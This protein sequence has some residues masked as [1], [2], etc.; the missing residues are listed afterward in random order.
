MAKKYDIVLAT[1]PKSD[2]NAPLIA[3]FL[4]K[5]ILQKNGF[6]CK[7]VDWNRDLYEKTGDKDLFDRGLT[8]NKKEF[9]DKVWDNK[10]KDI[11]LTWIKELKS[12]NSEWVG[13]SF[14]SQ[15]NTH[16]GK[17]ILELI[18]KNIPKIKIVV[19]GFMISGDNNC[20]GPKFLEDGLIDYFI[21]GE[22]EDAIVNLLQGNYDFSGINKLGS[23]IPVDINHEF[24]PDYSDVVHYKYKFYDIY[25]SRGCVNNCLFCVEHLF[26]KGYRHR[27]SEF[28][29]KEMLDIRNKY[30]NRSFRFVDSL[31]NG[32]P[33]EFRKLCHLLYDK[34]FSWWGNFLITKW[35]TE[36]DFENASRAGLK[37]IS[38]GVE[39][40]SERIRYE[41][42]KGFSNV[43]LYNTV[44]YAM[45]N[46]IKF[47]ANIMV[48]WPTET[49]QDF[50]ET[51]D[52]ITFLSKY[53]NVS[54]N[55]GP[56]VRTGKNAILYEKYKMETD[57]NG[58]WVYQNNNY[59]VR[60]NR[61][62]KL[63]DHCKNFGVNVSEH[64][65][66]RVEETFNDISG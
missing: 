16:M 34:K 5:S 15:R 44:D 12:Y 54:I 27:K 22:G 48:G 42:R 45:K 11:C 21:D 61:W 43:N 2:H 52:F 19:G 28:V 25:N 63:V 39:S 60:K 55:P 62:I 46:N 41:M 30:N 24:I 23:W 26:A 31:I 47:S 1:I 4:L 20:L 38:V 7:A 10:L 17:R 8:F 33:K 3:P 64:H 59:E 58:H 65:R 6:T 49:D 53:K 57:E 13:I 37:D 14:L 56:T 35:L 66:D 36:K 9:F 51:L 40:A 50:N 29:Y 32:N 18:R